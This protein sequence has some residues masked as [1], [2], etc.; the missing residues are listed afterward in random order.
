FALVVRVREQRR[1][2]V[3]MVR[4]WGWARDAFGEIFQRHMVVTLG[5]GLGTGAAFAFLPTFAEDLGVRTLTIFYT[6]YSGAAIAVR[7][8]GGRLIDT[9]GRRAVIVPSMFCQAAAM[10]LLA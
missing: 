5:F 7:V 9:R 2:D 4:G 3:P 1:T 8:V 6:A 10:A